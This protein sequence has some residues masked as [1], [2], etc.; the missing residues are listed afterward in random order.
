MNRAASAPTYCDL[1]VETLTR[2][3]MRDAFVLGDRRM[4]YAEAASLV[5]R[6][7]QVLHQL[8]VRRG[9]TVAV[10]SP[11]VPEAWI[12]QAATH[13]LGA[14]FTGLHALGSIAD[15]VFICDDAE[16]DVI[17]VHPKF[18]ATGAAVRD[19]SASV[20]HLLTL[21][22]SEAG[23]DLLRLVETVDARPLAAIEVDEEDTTWL[24]YTGGTT[25]KPKGAMISHRA[26]VQQVQSVAAGWALPERPIYHAAA[27]ITHGAALALVPALMRGGTVVLEQG[28]DPEQ[29]LTTLAA[30]RVNYAFAVPTMLYTLMDTTDV[31]AF[32]TSS[33]QTLVYGAAPMAPQ[34]IEEAHGVF[35][36]VL[37]QAYGQSESFG[38]GTNLRHEEHDPVGRPGL[39]SSCGRPVPG[40]TI[41]LLGDDDHPVGEGQVGELCVRSRAVMNGY[42]KREAET[43]QALRGGW[44]HTS[45]MAVR[46]DEGFYHLVDRKKDMIVTGGFNVYPKEIEDVLTSAPEVS[47]AAVIGVPDA[48]WGEQVRAYVVVRPGAAVDAAVLTALVRDRKGPHQTPKMIEL[49]D[50]LPMTAVGK[51][52][53]K[54]LRS[55]HWSPGTRQVN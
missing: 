42:W 35:G 51:I 20:R 44:L 18:E 3:P 43:A 22:P 49:V 47:A 5:S 15:Q 11:N 12:V 23:R 33:L 30:E 52:D 48:R 28:F 41:E 7:E 14:R 29:W 4:T 16:V 19:G 32:D 36:P 24:Q 10:L 54:A 50:E 55:R 46:D 45:D 53:K 17:V 8:G 6:T 26:V 13:L 21:G 1:L 2:N 27:P 9:G 34:R 39:L 25:G 40:V 37:F 38:M 31:G